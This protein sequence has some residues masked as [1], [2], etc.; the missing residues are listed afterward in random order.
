MGGHHHVHARINGSP[1]GGEF[2]VKKFVITAV[3]QR[4]ARVAVGVGVAV[5]G[6]MLDAGDDARIAQPFDT[7]DAVL[8]DDPGVIT[9]RAHADDG[10]RR[11]VVHIQNRSK[12]HIEAEQL[13]LFPVHPC[14]VPRTGGI[15]GGSQCHIAD[16]GGAEA[17]TRHV[18]ALLIRSDKGGRAAAAERRVMKIRHQPQ[19]LFGIREIL[20]IHQDAAEAVVRKILPLSVA[21]RGDAL[22]F[23]G[24]GVFPVKARAE[25]HH[26]RQLVPQGHALH[27]T[28]NRV[29]RRFAINGKAKDQRKQQNRQR[30]QQRLSF[31]CFLFH[32]LL[33][34]TAAARSGCQ[35]L[36]MV[37]QISSVS[38][39]F[40]LLMLLIHYTRLPVKGK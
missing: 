29:L 40:L 36:F 33:L 15:T 11:V 3:Y 17:D 18:A 10:I 9:E 16:A 23:F 6:K 24:I 5:P 1:E 13:Q 35:R 2:Y 39:R 38:A 22:P 31:L 32:K 7:G 26:L 14:H 25:E 34:P 27:D 4:Q 12:I 37:F 28:V 8:S 30:D 20:P 19:G 21:E